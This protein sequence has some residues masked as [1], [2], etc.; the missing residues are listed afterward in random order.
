MRQKLKIKRSLRPRGAPS[1]C[2]VSSRASGW[3]LRALRHLVSLVSIQCE[4]A[5]NLRE[6]T[7][8]T[9]LDA[10]LGQYREIVARSDHVKFLWYPHTGFVVTAT[11]PSFI[12]QRACSCCRIESHDGPC[13]FST[14][15]LVQV[16]LCQW[17]AFHTSPRI[18]N[19]LLGFYG[20][21]SALYLARFVPRLVCA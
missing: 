17:L 20:L 21:E 1:G 15:V 11:Y 2:S 14:S 4:H 9:T 13:A 7:H 3:L 19:T 16:V 18:R 10:I 5:F 12:H 6:Y 8:P